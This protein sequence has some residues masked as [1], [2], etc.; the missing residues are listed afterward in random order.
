MP[1]SAVAARSSKSNLLLGCV[2]SIVSFIVPTKVADIKP[3][4]IAFFLFFV[5]K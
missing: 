3:P 2:A 5:F 1:P 4:I